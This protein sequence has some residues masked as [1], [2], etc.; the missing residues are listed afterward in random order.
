M[1]ILPKA[2]SGLSGGV[3]TGLTVLFGTKKRLICWTFCRTIGNLPFG[4][5]VFDN[6]LFGNLVTW[7]STI[8]CSVIWQLGFQQYVVR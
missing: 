5:L 1:Y 8:C 2:C 7:F 6:L 3:N 4:N